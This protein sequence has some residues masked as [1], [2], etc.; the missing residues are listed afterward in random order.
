MPEASSNITEL[1]PLELRAQISSFFPS[2]KSRHQTVTNT[3]APFQKTKIERGCLLFS[4][5][6]VFVIAVCVYVMCMYVCVCV[7]VRDDVCESTGGVCH[8]T[9]F[10]EKQLSGLSSCLP[11]Y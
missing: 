6:N 4:F 10:Q 3:M 7:Y 11:L 9:Q 1:F 2:A 5:K 8:G